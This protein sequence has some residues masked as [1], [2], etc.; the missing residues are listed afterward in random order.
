MGKKAEYGQGHPIFLEYAEQI[1]QHKEYQGMPDLRYPDGRI[2]WEA[3]SN[4]KSGI[5]KDTNIKRRKWWEQKAISI[6]ID[7][8]SNQWI[9]KTAK[10]IHPTMRK[11]CKKC[12]RIMDLRYSYPTKN[13]IKR[14]RKLPYVDES[15]EIDS[16][17]HI[18]KLIKRLVL[19]YGDKVYDDLPKLLTC[20]AV[21][22]IPRLGN[23]L[24]TWLNWIDSVYIPSEPSMLSPGA[25]ANPPDRLDGFHS[26][27][28]C[29]RSHADRGRWEKN[30]RSFT[31]DRRAFEYWVDG[32]WVAADKLMGLIR[33]NEQ[34]KKETCLNDN[35]T[36]PCSADHIGPISLGFVHRPEFQLLCNSCNSA[37]NNRMTFSDV[38]HLIN[39][40]NNGEEVASWYCKHIW[41]LRKHDVKNNENA[42]RLSKILRDNRHTAMFIL[43]ELL[44]DNHY[45][46]LSTFLGLQYAERSVSFSNIKIE[47]H[48]ITGQ[49]SEQPRD[50]K[51][52]EEQKAR[53]MRIGF[54]A[55]KS[56]IE[57]ENRNALLVINDKIIDK[58]NEIKNILQDIPDEYKLLNEKISEQFN[59]EEV[60][61]ELL[62]DLV[63]H[64]PTK[65]SEPANFKLARK[66]LQEI[67]EIVGDELSKMWEDERYVRQTFADLD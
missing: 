26:L 15:F 53:R 60:S 19:Q 35:H 31:T 37:K 22:N 20:K 4:R 1:I 39:A 67:M 9:S 46:F 47:N 14:I 61:D 42:L 30:L 17:E 48:I 16:L 40:E 24:D 38:Q 43:S 10:L 55:L 28:E 58:I 65:E 11:P 66:Y 54:E 50:T 33:T 2:Q 49:I 34:I 62:R 52:T 45:L 59:S 25:M 32:D 13:L 51:Y 64:L 41:D 23:D 12:G 8:S 63:T 3:P 7:P 6:G 27:N 56:Y 57:K 21:K 29:C 44:K 18:L 36:G 5:F